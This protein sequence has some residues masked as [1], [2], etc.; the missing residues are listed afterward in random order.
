LLVQQQQGVG[1]LVIK[2]RPADARLLRRFS[3]AI[4][5]DA[6]VR[7]LADLHSVREV[8][9]AVASP[10]NSWLIF[11]RAPLAALSDGTTFRECDGGRY[12][13]DRLST[14]LCERDKP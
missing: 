9:G 14:T 3:P 7:K 6:V 11:A 5:H 12:G 13:A 8:F 4:R 2:L 10:F 1:L